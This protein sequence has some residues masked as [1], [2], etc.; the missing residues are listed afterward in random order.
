M[1]DLT[2]T[3]ILFL[4]L[5]GQVKAMLKEGPCFILFC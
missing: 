1:P 4:F 2:K 5:S 3:K